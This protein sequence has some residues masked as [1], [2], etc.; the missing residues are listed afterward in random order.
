VLA[1]ARSFRGVHARLYSRCT[2][3]LQFVPRVMAAS[4]DNLKN[5]PSL[6]TKAALKLF[7]YKDRRGL[8]SVPTASGTVKAPSSTVSA[9]EGQK[10]DQ[11]PLFP[12]MGT[13]ASNT[14]QTETPCSNIQSNSNSWG[15]PGMSSPMN[16]MMGMPPWNTMSCGMGMNPASMASNPGMMNQNMGP[17][18]AMMQFW[19]N[20]MMQ[21]QGQSNW[22]DPYDEEEGV[23]TIPKTIHKALTTL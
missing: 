1:C 6:P 22:N 8:M 17:M 10:N 13:N 14:S 16:P 12:D 21:G 15:N 5:S 19:Q 20:Q 11:L 23:K 2:C 4:N 9:P 7:E 3:Y 18:W